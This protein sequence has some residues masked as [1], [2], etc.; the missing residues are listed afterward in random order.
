MRKK[1]PEK[2]AAIKI[3]LAHR[4]K[5]Q[6]WFK[7]TQENILRIIEFYNKNGNLKGI[8]LKKTTEKQQKFLNSDEWKNIRQVVLNLYE[9]VCMKCGDKENI[10][11]DHIKPKSKYPE[12]ALSVDNLQ[13]LCWPCNKKKGNKNELDYRNKQVRLAL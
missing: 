5:G 13:I 12:I 8:R 3:W 4:P 7:T 2:S 11:V 10:Q 9:P 1:N 6:V